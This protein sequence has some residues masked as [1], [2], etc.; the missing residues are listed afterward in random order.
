[1]HASVQNI[2]RMQRPGAVCTCVYVDLYVHTCGRAYVCV[3]V[4]LC[5]YASMYFS[6]T[7]IYPSFPL[8]PFNTLSLRSPL[9][10]LVAEPLK[11]SPLT[12]SNKPECKP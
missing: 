11:L 7:F 2:P 10:T 5:V 6:Y 3:Y 12:H 8:W 9:Q 1:M 4:Y